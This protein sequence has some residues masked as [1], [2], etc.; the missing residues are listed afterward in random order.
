MSKNPP[1]LEDV[2]LEAN[3]LHRHLDAQKKPYSAMVVSDCIVTIAT[4]TARVEELEK[5]LREC[6]A[7]FSTNPGSVAQCQAEIG[8]EFQ[9]R[10]DIAN[11][12]LQPKGAA[13]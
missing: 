4:L 9:R 6:G 13:V 10:M 2:L 1:S 12:V 5:A 11:A 8:E 3:E 7:E